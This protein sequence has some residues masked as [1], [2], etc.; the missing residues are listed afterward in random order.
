MIMKKRVFV[1]ID[2]FEEIMGLMN[3]IRNKLKDA[4]SALEG[5][6]ELKHDEDSE[7][8]LWEASLS[9]IETRMLEI[10]NTLSGSEQTG[11]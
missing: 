11:D 2:E 5:I 9:D 1:K 4:K 10:G 8:G 7:I 3:E 6:K